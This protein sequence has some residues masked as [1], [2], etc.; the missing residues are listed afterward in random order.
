[1][2]GWDWL[3]HFACAEPD[4]R[5]KPVIRWSFRRLEALPGGTISPSIAPR[6]QLAGPIFPSD[7][8]TK[9]VTQ[10]DQKGCI[11]IFCLFTCNL[12]LF[13][14]LFYLKF[15]VLLKVISAHMRRASMRTKILEFYRTETFLGHLIL[16]GHNSFHTID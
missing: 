11:T 12:F 16:I 3:N 13:I 1:M 4:M 9:S 15:Y 6:P 10:K 5:G 14:Y 7:H 8:P 2:Y